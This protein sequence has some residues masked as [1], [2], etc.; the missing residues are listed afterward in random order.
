MDGALLLKETD[1]AIEQD[2][3][4][5]FK[6]GESENL[7]KAAA[8]DEGFP[9][10]MDHETQLKSLRNQFNYAERTSQSVSYA[11]KERGVSTEPPPTSNF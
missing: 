10:K 6:K 11:I 2:E 4:V 1:E 7:L 9:T 3:F 5:D 8:I